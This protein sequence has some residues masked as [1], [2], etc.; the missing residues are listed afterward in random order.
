MAPVGAASYLG[1]ASEALCWGELL[2]KNAAAHLEIIIT[3]K[4]GHI[5]FIRPTN[6]YCTL[7][8]TSH[9]IMDHEWFSW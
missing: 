9:Q 5:F 6:K 2:C 3:Y 1:A 8:G 4:S 7:A